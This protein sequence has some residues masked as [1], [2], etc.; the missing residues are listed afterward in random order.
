MGKLVSAALDRLVAKPGR[1]SDGDGL[2]FRSRGLGRAY[3]VYRYRSGGR[4]RE[5]SIGPYPAIKLKEARERHTELRKRVVVDKADPLAL[6]REAKAQA[7]AKAAKPTFGALA[8]RHVAAHESSWKSAKHRKQWLSTLTKHCAAIRDLPVDEVDTAAVLR[9]L[10]PIWKKTPE[11]ASRLRARIEAVLAAAQVDGLTDEARPNPARWKNWLDKKLTSPTK[12]DARRGHHAAMPYADLPAFM[13]K[14]DDAQGASA[15]SA[16]AAC[17]AFAIL[18]AAR[19][20]EALGATWDEIDLNAGVWT[21]RGER[22]KGGKEHR[23]PLSEAAATILK[24]K[25][26]ERVR[27]HSHI[28]PGARPRRPLGP[29]ALTQAMRKLG[30]GSV[31]V[32]GFRSAF[33]DWAGDETSF[34]REVAEAALAHAV[35]DE[36]EKAYRRSDALERRRELM[37]AWGSFCL[38]ESAKDKVV[39]IAAGRKRP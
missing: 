16:A 34:P 21:V 6:K 3:W 39:P 18:T 38:P 13:A 30:A 31:T 25:R 12:G 7:L 2:F 32:H 37:E 27:S 20:G 15:G 24:R 35:G 8:D 28:F 1:H 9:V 36:T 26:A 19:S 29:M 23:V 17:L 5:F 4:E 11:T 33:R 22:M 14:L 10:T